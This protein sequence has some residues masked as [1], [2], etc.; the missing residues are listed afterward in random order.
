MSTITWITA[1]FSILSIYLIHTVKRR[2]LLL[3]VNA[4]CIVEWIL[5][6]IAQWQVLPYVGF[7]GRFLF[8]FC[9]YGLFSG[10]VCGHLAF[11]L[12]LLS[13]PGVLLNELCAFATKAAVTKFLQFSSLFLSASIGIIY[14]PLEHRTGP[15]FNLPFILCEVILFFV[16]YNIL[17]ETNIRK[18]STKSA[19]NYGA[20]VESRRWTLMSIE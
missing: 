5:L 4:L 16:I 19:K 3:F 8:L 6:S 14:L 18:E 13:I 11:K 9:K 2:P 7:I 15:I 1:P 17:P 12:G 20:I 10:M